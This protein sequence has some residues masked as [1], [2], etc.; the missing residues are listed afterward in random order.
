MW[1]VFYDYREP[2]EWEPMRRVLMLLCNNIISHP[3]YTQWATD[4]KSNYANATNFVRNLY[5]CMQCFV[6]CTYIFTVAHQKHTCI[7]YIEF[8]IL[9]NGDN[10][11]SVCFLII[12]G[13]ESKANRPSRCSYKASLR[14]QCPLFPIYILRSIVSIWY[15]FFFF[16]F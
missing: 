11:I 12:F 5:K 10:C 6:W 8:S 7:E 14:D 4:L 15:V 1:T 3:R 13:L 2:I 9:G 16:S